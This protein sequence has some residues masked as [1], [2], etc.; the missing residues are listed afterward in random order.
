[1][2]IIF[3]GFFWIVAYSAKMLFHNLDPNLLKD[4]LAKRLSRISKSYVDA[5][6]GLSLLLV[7]SLTPKGFSPCTPVFPSLQKPVFP[8][9]SQSIRNQVD[10][11]PLRGSAISK[12]LFIYLFFTAQ[13][14]RPR[15]LQ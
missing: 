8:T 13:W 4:L 6:C 14:I 11:E 1:M 9:E 2:N 15:P 5:I 10:E 12:L 7:L 3:E